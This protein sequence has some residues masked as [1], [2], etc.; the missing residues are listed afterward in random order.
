M[1]GWL[2]RSACL[3]EYCAFSSFSLCAASSFV[4]LSPLINFVRKIPISS[5][6]THISNMS[7]VL[8]FAV[9]CYISIYIF[10][11]EHSSRPNVYAEKRASTQTIVDSFFMIYYFFRERIK[12]NDD[13]K[14][15]TAK[16]FTKT[17]THAHT[18]SYM[19]SGF[20]PSMLQNF[21]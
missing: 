13:D 9:R 8:P 6:D 12:A 3:F 7:S 17:H 1:Y 4:F 20:L 2:C 19:G 16:S 10:K 21:Q 15:T 11:Q 5:S 14:K 18:H